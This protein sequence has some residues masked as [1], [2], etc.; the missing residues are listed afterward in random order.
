MDG[1][2]DASIDS[3][4][5]SRSMFT[6]LMLNGKDD[7][8]S[9]VFLGNDLHADGDKALNGFSSRGYVALRFRFGVLV[10]MIKISRK[11]SLSLSL[12]LVYSGNYCCVATD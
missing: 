5:S 7:Y 3:A 8:E 11:K 12:Q 9:A 10:F 4:S 1:I 6:E 2:G